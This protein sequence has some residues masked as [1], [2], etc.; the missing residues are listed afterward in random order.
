M[1]RSRLVYVMFVCLALLLAAC[2]TKRKISSNSIPIGPLSTLKSGFAI[3]PDSIQTSTYWY[4][5]SDNI[6]KEGVIRDLESMKK[7]GINRAFIGNI[8]QDDVPAGK[9][10]IFTDEWW[11]VLHAALKKATELNIE[12]GIFNSPGW[13][14]SGGPWVKPEQSMRYLTSTKLHVKGPLKL[15]QKLIKPEGD[16]QDVKLIAYPVNSDFA[17]DIFDRKP[18]IKATPAIEGINRIMDHNDTTG[19]I[20]KKED[21]YRIDITVNKP[22]TVRSLVITPNRSAMTI[23]GQL[24]V[25]KNGMYTTIKHFT[26]DRSNT[27]LNVG[28]MPYGPAAFAI[29]ATASKS[30]RLLL[31][32]FSGNSGIAEVKLSAVPAVENYIEKTF[33]NMWQTPFPYLDAYQWGPQP[34]I[35]NKETVIDPVKVVDISNNM[36]ANGELKWDVPPGS[37]VIERSGMTPTK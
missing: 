12:I 16:F 4:W 1:K 23:T 13:S 5:I 15:N 36:N 26:V 30:F 34:L 33:A 3:V 9:V 22:Y 32:K 11:E 18:L 24:Q 6:S 2:A 14:Q 28:F 29:P 37:W 25:M 35:D 20:F 27:E 17:G 8:W 7:V 21:T 31:T 19:V 10:K